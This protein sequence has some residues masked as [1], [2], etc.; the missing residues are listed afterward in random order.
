MGVVQEENAVREWWEQWR[1]QDSMRV[2]VFTASYEHDDGTAQEI[3][4]QVGPE[5]RRRRNR[6]AWGPNQWGQVPWP[7]P[8][9]DEAT[10]LERL[11]AEVE[12]VAHVLGR[13]PDLFGERILAASLDAGYSFAGAA[14]HL[15]LLHFYTRLNDRME[16]IG[17]T[18]ETYLHEVGHLFEDEYMNTECWETARVS[19]GVPISDYAALDTEEDFAESLF[20]YYMVRYRPGR[21]ESEV[22]STIKD[23]IPARI[24]CLD[25]WGFGTGRP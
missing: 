18:E 11:A 17:A 12:F 5:W 15:Q 19:D 3:E 4:I 14:R 2:R 20:A 21:V 25:G 23:T 8:L 9:Y 1:W 22:L 7:S 6:N 24:A 13:L 10:E 16:S